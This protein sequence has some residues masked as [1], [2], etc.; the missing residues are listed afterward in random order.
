M[1]NYFLYIKIFKNAKILEKVG[2][3]SCFYDKK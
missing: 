3:K 2:G 1:Q